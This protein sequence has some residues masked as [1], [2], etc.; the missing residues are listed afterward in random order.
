[1]EEIVVTTTEN[2]TRTRPLGVWVFSLYAFLF[3]GLF[4]FALSMYMLVSGYSTSTPGFSLLSMVF[5]A[6]LA[7][8]IAVFS[9]QLWRGNEHGRI[10]FLVL[11]TI[12][13]LFIAVNNYLVIRTGLTPSESMLQLWGN[14]IRG[15]V[16]PAIYIYYFNRASTRSFYRN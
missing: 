8:A 4:S 3:N 11:I 9:I 6:V 5:S 2:E 15:F 16:Y 1:M 10:I 12:N 7:A 13:Y 14:V